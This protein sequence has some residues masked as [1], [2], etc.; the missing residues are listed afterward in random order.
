MGAG[1]STAANQDTSAAPDYYTLLEVEENASSD[2]IK[3]SFRRLALIHHPDKNVDDPEGATKRFAAL[4]QAYEVLSD[5][6]ERAWYDSHRASLVPE[7]DEKSVYE[8]IRKGAP[9]PRTRGRGLTARHLARFFDQTVW[10]GFSDEGDGFYAIYRNL[11][12]RLQAEEELVSDGSYPSF[13][14]STWS[15]APAHKGEEATAA[16]TFYNTW[17]NFATS[18]DFAWMD[19]W[20]PAE[21]P[22][23]RVRRLM[24]KDNKKVREDAR[25]DYNDTVRSLAKFIRKRDPRYKTHL[26]RQAES[27]NQVSGTSTPSQRK[28]GH[29]QDLAAKY[30]EQD[31]QKLDTRGDDDLEWAAAEGEDPE[32]WECV[33]CGKSFR[34][35]AAWDSHERSKKHMKEVERL[36]REMQD[37][38][39][40]L[41]LG[42]GET[43]S[44][45]DDDPGLQ[46]SADIAPD[47]DALP[48]DTFPR[49]PLATDT[50]D[51]GHVQSKKSR[52]KKASKSLEPI[53]RPTKTE[54]M[55][56]DVGEL[57]R[58]SGTVGDDQDQTTGGRYDNEL[59]S[60]DRSG[61]AGDVVSEGPEQLSKKEIRRAK[62]AKK[63]E[64]KAS[65]TF[66]CNVCKAEFPSKTKLFTHIKEED[67]ALTDE[68]TN[69]ASGRGK[70]GKGKR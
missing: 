48:D 64:T 18:K 15:W 11:F 59:E 62:Q 60:R 31:W 43:Q 6:Q 9:P 7:P 21:G 55:M 3:R 65:E 33:A 5:D 25:R 39:F 23:R 14:Y 40:E 70:K 12:A 52:K 38:N 34:S 4:Q 68:T 36:R 61:G 8:D 35:E 44:E 46:T 17:M 66:R 57:D 41:G 58:V 67:H 19:Q 24:E 2:E 45:P 20:N 13:G 42:D 54:K 32:E 30:V 37:E 16:R 22:D 27:Q 49:T 56:R 28:T 69:G 10:T 1:A 51:N 26:A 29:V 53:G 63:M 47:G 50:I